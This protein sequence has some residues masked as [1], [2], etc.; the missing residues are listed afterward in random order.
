MTHG[1]SGWLAGHG[2]WVAKRCIEKD[3][4]GPPPKENPQGGG[5]D[6]AAQIV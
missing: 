4:Q 2:S 6:I 1:S 3:V 5:P